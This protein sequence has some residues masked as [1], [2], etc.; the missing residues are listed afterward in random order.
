M[1]GIC[2]SLYFTVHKYS[3]II[4]SSYEYGIT[5]AHPQ[6]MMRL[7]F[8]RYVMGFSFFTMVLAEAAIA[9][10]TEYPTTATSPP[11]AIPG[12]LSV[13]T[14]DSAEPVTQAQVELLMDGV[15]LD[16]H[17]YRYLLRFERYENFLAY[18]YELNARLYESGERRIRTGRVLLITSVPM[19]VLGGIAL[20]ETKKNLKSETYEEG[21]NDSWDLGLLAIAA[22]GCIVAGGAMILSGLIAL[23]TGMDRKEK[24][25]RALKKMKPYVK[26]YAPE[27]AKRFRLSGIGIAP[28]RNGAIMAATVNF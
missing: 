16:R 14:V 19:L 17:Y 23:T 27:T 21:S 18:A 4:I 12:T 8:F 2:V 11:R 20:Y 1:T 13:A 5:F 15:N 6:P 7:L 25:A 26:F 9:G 10:A 3:I 28:A 24:A 22:G